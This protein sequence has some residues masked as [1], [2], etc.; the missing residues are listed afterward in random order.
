MWS[1]KLPPIWIR[2]FIPS[3][4]RKTFFKHIHY[5][6]IFLPYHHF[7]LQLLS[8]EKKVLLPYTSAQN[9]LLLTDVFE[10]L[11]LWFEKDFVETLKLKGHRSSVKLLQNVQVNNLEV[12]Q[13]HLC[14]LFVTD[15][16][17]SYKNL[18]KETSRKVSAWIDS[19]FFCV[20]KNQ[21]ISQFT[22]IKYMKSDFKETKNYVE[23]VYFLQ[24]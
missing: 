2:W 24:L 5:F 15:F 14:L 17:Q 23:L 16:W 12:C 11:D 8:V 10:V 9:Y 18:M 6:W 19:W 22:W 20:L 3:T 21:L 13:A 1:C 4:L 7:Q